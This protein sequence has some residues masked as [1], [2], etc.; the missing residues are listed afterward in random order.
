MGKY[1][2][3]L[4]H[5]EDSLRDKGYF[6]IQNPDGYWQWSYGSYKNPHEYMGEVE[7]IL[8]AKNFED[9]TEIDLTDLD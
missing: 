4:I 2:D 5:T 7:A 6:F 9:E 1:K 8:S 3:W